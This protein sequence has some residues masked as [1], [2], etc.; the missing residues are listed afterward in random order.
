M[1]PFEYKAS[2]C[3]KQSKALACNSMQ[4]ELSPYQVNYIDENE[5]IVFNKRSGFRTHKVNEN[6]LGLVEVLSAKTN[7]DLLVVHRLDKETSGLILFA[8][9]KIAAAKLSNLFEQHQIKK[10]YFFLTDHEVQFT[11]Q[12]VVSH[13][14]KSDKTYI[15]NPSREPNSKTLFKY[16]Q[17]ISEH[18]H[19][20][21]AEPVSGKPHQIRLHAELIKIPILGDSEHGGSHFFRLAL[22]SGKIEFNIDQKLYS[23]EAELPFCFKNPVKSLGDFLENEYQDLQKI[24]K[25]NS[26]Q[27]YRLYHRSHHEQNI[28][29]D[30]YGQIIWV[31]W[32]KTEPPTQE[33]LN[34]TEDFCKRHNLNY[35][36]RHMINRGTGVGGLEH[37]DLYY[38][39]TPEKWIALEH[40]L[41]AEL[42]RDQGFSPGLFLDQRSNRQF[43]F[44]HS[45]NK[46]VLNLFSYTSLFSVAAALGQAQSVTTV[47]ASPNFLNWSKENFKIN[48]IDPENKA[49]EF[50]AQDSLLFLQGSIKRERKWDI[51]ICDPPSFGRTKK[52]T[53]KIE[54]DLP[55]LIQ[56][57]WACLNPNGFILF[58]CNYEKWTLD[59]IEKMFKKSLNG[60]RFLIQNLPITDLD[61]EFP[62]AFDNLLKGVLIYRK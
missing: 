22:H 29:V 33:D 56:A 27:T 57:M 44:N 28:R 19:L 52:T 55:N 18:C 2:S 49:Y 60:S 31:Y 12:T 7:L 23:Y 20:W 39:N 54:K 26:Q 47:D 35:V 50:F 17:K 38:S 41:K 32:Y 37:K 1:I 9:N 40:Q 30:L 14:E 36:I 42:R 34:S 6:Q 16:I 8:K 10:T 58:T 24:Y 3:L 61:F 53:W 21:E 62:D 5:F 4:L 11:K 51:I 25:I 13:I 15:N 43:I 46:N 45:K 48:S 59:D